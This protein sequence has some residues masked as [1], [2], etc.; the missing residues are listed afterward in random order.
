MQCNS[1]W[2]KSYGLLKLA[3]FSTQFLQSYH[4]IFLWINIQQS[5]L[6]YWFHW[7]SKPWCF[8]TVLNMHL[9]VYAE[10]S[11]KFFY[12]PRAAL[13][14]PCCMD[15]KPTPGCWSAIDPAS[16][17]LRSESYFKY[18]L[19]TFVYHIKNDICINLT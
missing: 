19:L 12:R 3:C 7:I 16:F 1:T 2:L 18:I 6:H 17:T 5:I 4:S 15:E 14:I 13:S 10:S 9:L 11:Q 8:S